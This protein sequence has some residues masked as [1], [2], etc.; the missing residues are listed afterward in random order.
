MLVVYPLLLGFA[1]YPTG[2]FAATPTGQLPE[3]AVAPQTAAESP[4]LSSVES[5][6][7]R[8]TALPTGISFRSIVK[9]SWCGWLPQPPQFK[10]GWWIDSEW[11]DGQE[12]APTC[13]SNEVT[14]GL[15]Y[16]PNGVY[17]GCPATHPHQ[18]LARIECVLVPPPPACPTCPTCPKEGLVDG[19]PVWE[20]FA[21]YKP[22]APPVPP[23]LPTPAPAWPAMEAR[24]GMAS[25]RFH[26]RTN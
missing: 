2:E 21:E 8:A 11:K 9:T 5:V 16:S 26:C 25:L 12:V 18:W 24:A 22:A 10:L 23:A 1:S 13:A 15:V 3:G 17:N 14:S 7:T 6:E 20:W 19:I 4:Q